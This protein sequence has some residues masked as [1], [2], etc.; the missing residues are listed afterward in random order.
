MSTP[1]ILRRLDQVTPQLISPTDTVRLAL[2]AGPADNS[3]TSVFYEVW[4]PGGA[5]PDNSHPEST[6]IFVV[7]AGHGT[8]HSDEHAVPIGPGDVL[9]LPPGSLHRIENTSATERM[10]T[11]TIMAE[12]GGAMPGGFASLVTAGTDSA[13]DDADRA[14]L[15]GPVRPGPRP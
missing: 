7:L 5:Q 15:S 12:D 4:E 1:P 2:L 6:E 13:W 3:P 9:V 14:V 10:Y 11:V 8:A